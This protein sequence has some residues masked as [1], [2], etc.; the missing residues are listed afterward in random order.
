MKGNIAFIV[1]CGKY[2]TG[3]SF[4]LNKLIDVQNDGVWIHCLYIS[5]KSIHQQVLVHKEFGYTQNL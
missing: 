2:R 4:L 3:K 5:L 1:M